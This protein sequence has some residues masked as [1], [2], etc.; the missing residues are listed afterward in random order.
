MDVVQ[1]LRTFGAL[2]TVLG[3]LA[4]ALWVVKRY[5]IKLPGRVGGTSKRRL[6]I[7]EKL[8]IDNRRSVALIRRDGHEHLILLAP[9]GPLMIEGGIERAMVPVPFVPQP[10]PPPP[11]PETAP[12]TTVDLRAALAG[13]LERARSAPRHP[14][15]ARELRHSLESLTALAGSSPSALSHVP[16]R[17]DF[18]QTLVDVEQSRWLREAR[19]RDLDAASQTEPAHA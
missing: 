12:P 9:E 8:A 5:D 10:A 11:V 15:A 2:G 16:E 18:R 3:L 19:K 13:L 17:P 6:E 4:G 1:L 7:V 14:E